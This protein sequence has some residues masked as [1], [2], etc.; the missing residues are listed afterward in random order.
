MRLPV[1]S[2]G[3]PD[4]RHVHRGQHGFLR[5]LQHHAAAPQFVVAAAVPNQVAYGLEV[6]AMTRSGDWLRPTS[7]GAVQDGV[8][9]VRRS[10][11]SSFSRTVV[12]KVCPRLVCRLCILCVS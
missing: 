2:G 12:R 3:G 9:L 1:S 6:G 11:R 10:E 5:V 7:P 8:R 4:Q